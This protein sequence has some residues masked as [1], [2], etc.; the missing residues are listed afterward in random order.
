MAA[1]ANAAIP[2]PMAFVAASI[3]P[4]GLGE[5]LAQE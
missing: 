2:R 3:R 5:A 4:A 1:L